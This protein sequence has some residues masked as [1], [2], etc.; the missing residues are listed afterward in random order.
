[1]SQEKNHFHF[2]DKENLST[3]EEKNLLKIKENTEI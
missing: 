3:P 1:M 2:F